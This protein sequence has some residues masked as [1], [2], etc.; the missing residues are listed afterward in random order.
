M[1][2]RVVLPRTAHAAGGILLVWVACVGVAPVAAQQSYVV[3]TPLVGFAGA[4]VGGGDADLPRLFTETRIWNPGSRPANVRISDVV[5]QQGT[6]LA[7]TV[8]PQAVVGLRYLD[9]IAR[10]PEAWAMVEFSS[11]QEIRVSTTVNMSSLGCAVQTGSAFPAYTGGHCEGI[12]GPILKGFT[13]YVQPG[14]PANL[15]WLTTDTIFFRTNLFV[16][17]PAESTL[18]IRIVY[19]SADGSVVLEKEHTLGPR[20]LQ[21]IGDV[22]SDPLLR[23]LLQANGMNQMATASVTGDGP[24]YAFAAVRSKTNRPDSDFRFA[25]VQPDAEGSPTP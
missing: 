20:S 24:F 5:G 9:L 13:D 14:E 1:R 25:I 16:I 18:R 21:V 23:P 10:R 2:T 7:L 8:P 6:G 15:D 22:F 19:R 4:D 12:G 3:R 11:D 17:N